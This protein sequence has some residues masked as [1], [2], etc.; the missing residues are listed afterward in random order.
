MA[1][2]LDKKGPKAEDLLASMKKM[3]IK[4]NILMVNDKL[5]R[6]VKE[7]K[8]MDGDGILN[9]FEMKDGLEFDKIT[10]SIV[11]QIDTFVGKN[12]NE[13]ELQASVN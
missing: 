8:K 9:I 2:I 1:N 4:Y 7:F 11:R 13:P 12:S 6:M 10:Q 3:G 5:S